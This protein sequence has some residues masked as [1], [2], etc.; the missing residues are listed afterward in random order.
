L[1]NARKDNQPPQ[2]PEPAQNEDQQSAPVLDPETAPIQVTEKQLLT[3]E[4]TP[5]PTTQKKSKAS[6]TSGDPRRSSRLNIST[7]ND[8]ETSRR[9][10]RIKKATT[11][12]PKGN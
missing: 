1:K 9:S 10:S 2:I 8:I 11:A 6:M 7:Q 5:T 3:P 4:S 12:A